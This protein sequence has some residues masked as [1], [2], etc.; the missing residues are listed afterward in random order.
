MVKESIKLKKSIKV[1]SMALMEKIFI[2][3]LK[4]LVA[5]SPCT[6]LPMIRA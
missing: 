5:Q 1:Q 2:L 6:S 3:E 4:I